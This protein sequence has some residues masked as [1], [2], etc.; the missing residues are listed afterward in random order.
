MDQL[1]INGGDILEAYRHAGYFSENENAERASAWRLAAR[2]DVR[3]A[4][5]DVVRGRAIAHA[6]DVIDILKNIAGDPK[7]TMSTRVKA[8]QALAEIIG[9]NAPPEA[10]QVNV[11][12]RMSRPEYEKMAIT[13]LGK[14]N[15]EDLKVIEAE[16]TEVPNGHNQSSRP[17]DRRGEEGRRDPDGDTSPREASPG[18]GGRGP[19][20]PQ[21]SEERLQPDP[22]GR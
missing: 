10:Q 22:A 4:F 14:L 8:A 2:Q 7:A 12:V 6:P 16:Y 3:R 1:A 18:D 21:P 11:E 15:P 9:L 17:D 5:L 19:D 13:L 20:D